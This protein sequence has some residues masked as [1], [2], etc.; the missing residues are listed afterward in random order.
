[1]D[2]NKLELSSR[3]RVSGELEGGLFAHVWV[4]YSFGKYG[5]RKDLYTVKGGVV[6]KINPDGSLYA[7]GDALFD[8]K[9][10]CHRIGKYNPNKTYKQTYKT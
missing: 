7:T 3:L 9:L 6:Y 8:L 5:V 4:N 2:R 10:D 1:M